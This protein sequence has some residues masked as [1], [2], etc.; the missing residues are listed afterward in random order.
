MTQR[1][2]YDTVTMRALIQRIN[3]RLKREHQDGERNLET[4]KATRSPRARQDLGDYYLLNLERN[5]ITGT[6]V[7]LEKFGRELGVLQ[8][9]ERVEEDDA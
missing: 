3:R 6:H 5:L 7:D 4:V 2:I 1:K 9:Y 8:R